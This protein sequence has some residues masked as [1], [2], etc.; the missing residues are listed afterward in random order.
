MS[1]IVSFRSPRHCYIYF[2]LFTLYLWCGKINK[3][4]VLN[5]FL[6]KFLK[7][8]VNIPAHVH[9][10]KCFFLFLINVMA[11]KITLTC[12]SVITFYN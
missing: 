2:F 5:K 9:E 6:K 7:G 1:F 3:I 12:T 10:S 11:L 4:N 8:G